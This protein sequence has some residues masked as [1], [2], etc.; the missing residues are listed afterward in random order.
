MPNVLITCCSSRS[1]DGDSVFCGSGLGKV[2]DEGT[3]TVDRG[4]NELAEVAMSMS[5]PELV[6][7]SESQAG[8]HDVS[9]PPEASNAVSKLLRDKYS[10]WRESDRTA[11][12][13]SRTF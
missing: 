2:P 9:W 7:G 6:S 8:V 12:T 5:L 13:P 11:D 1:P 4:K 10:I 3:R